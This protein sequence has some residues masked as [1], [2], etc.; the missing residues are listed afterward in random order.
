MP[1]IKTILGM[2]TKNWFMASI[3][4][5]DA[6]YSVP[7]QQDFQ[8]FLKFSYKNKLYKFT[9]F[10]NGLAHCP[11]K[12][13][14]ITKVPMSKLRLAGCIIEGYIDDFFTQGGTSKACSSNIEKIITLFDKLG[15]VVHPDKSQLDPTQ[16]I[17]FLGFIID[18]QTME[19]FLT[20]KRINQLYILVCQLMSIT[21]PTI[22]LLAK[23]IGTI[24]S[25][26]PA[27][28]F[29]PLHYR[30][31]ENIKIEYL[32]KARGNFDSV[33]EIDSKGKQELIWW[34]ENIHHSKNWVS[35]PV[36]SKN[37]YT[38]ASSY[39][40]GAILEKT[41]TG[42]V[43]SLEEQNVHINCQELLAVFYALK[44]FQEKLKGLHISIFCDNTSAVGIINKMG[45]CKSSVA[46]SIVQK[47]WNLCQEKEIWITAAHIPGKDNVEAD[48][49]SRRAYRDSE[50]KLD[51]QL[52]KE[53]CYKLNFV[54]TIDCFASRLNT[55]LESYISYRPDPFATYIDAFSINWNNHQCYIF[56]PF[57]QI[58]RILQKIR[59]DKARAMVIVPN[60]PTQSWYNM[61]KNLAEKIYLITPHRKNLILPQDREAVHPLTKT[62]T[63]MVGVLSGKNI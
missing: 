11:R 6:Y 51:P 49:C 24:I 32:K 63:L 58:S 46:D 48:I 3:D 30:H 2:V 8:S 57:S 36:I 37:L 15:F 45:S 43:W 12:F 53:Y 54:P 52:F 47:I 7:I 25:S 14:K 18:S 60:W 13:T 20:P 62:L 4:L 59:T 33:C 23:V 35:P 50:W 31:L 1:S 26:L 19:V 9:V 40:W 56:P 44:S 22:R 21:K 10:P 16:R 28:K 5:K 55:Q 38:D 29:G 17:T 34:K 41:E 61:Y 27:V 39:A 42:G